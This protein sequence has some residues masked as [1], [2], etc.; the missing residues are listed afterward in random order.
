MSR[1]APVPPLS[2]AAGAGACL[3]Q[4]LFLPYPVLQELEPL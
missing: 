3:E 2:S 1:A 4:L